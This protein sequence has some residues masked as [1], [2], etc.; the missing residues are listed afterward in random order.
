MSQKR[1]QKVNYK[2]LWYEGK[3]R[4]NILKLIGCS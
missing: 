2:I 1:Q 3:L 4:Y